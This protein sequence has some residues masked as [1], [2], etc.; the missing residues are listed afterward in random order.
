MLMLFKSLQIFSGILAVLAFLVLYGF[1]DGLEGFIKLFT[2]L[3]LLIDIASEYP[4]L[5]IYISTFII[6]LIMFFV[7]KKLHYNK[8]Q[9][10]KNL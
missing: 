4:P 8:K 1:T 9:E 5:I 6:S 2:N 3:D 10:M 7:F